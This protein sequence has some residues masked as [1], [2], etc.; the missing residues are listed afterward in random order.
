MDGFELTSKLKSDQR[1]SHI[2]V[3]LLTAKV[4][5]KDKYQGLETGAD[6]Y[7]LK[8]FKSEHLKARVNNLIGIREKLKSRYTQELV[9][10]PKDL[11]IT[12]LDEIFLNP[13]ICLDVFPMCHIFQETSRVTL[14]GMVKSSGT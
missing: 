7:I 6:D 12:N 5:D 11:P 9:L 2:P 1:T 14:V 10:V 4:E 13:L 3:I 8:P